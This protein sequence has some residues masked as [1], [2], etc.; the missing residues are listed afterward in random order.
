M[1]V[2]VFRLLESLYRDQVACL[3]VLGL[4]DF[5]VCAFANKFEHP[6]LIHL[7]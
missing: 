1:G 6:V 7:S 3:P 2:L 4:V 5:A